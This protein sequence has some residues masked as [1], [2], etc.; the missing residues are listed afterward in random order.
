[1]RRRK[2]LY[3]YSPQAWPRYSGTSSGN[4]ELRQ[5][6]IAPQPSKT[7]LR[8]YATCSIIKFEYSFRIPF[9]VLSHHSAD[10][11]NFTAVTSAN[12][13]V[14]CAPGSDCQGFHSALMSLGGSSTV[15]RNL[16]LC[17]VYNIS[18]CIIIVKPKNSFLSL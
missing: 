11:A 3:K 8:G 9:L 12:G 2:T 10:S 7:R 6:A 16:L 17:C 15:H 18:Y 5:K 13:A 4:W 1:M 14:V